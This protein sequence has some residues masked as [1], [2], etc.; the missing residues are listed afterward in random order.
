MT[1][2]QLHRFLLQKRPFEL[3]T[4]GGESSFSFDYVNGTLVIIS[5][6]NVSTSVP[7]DL[8]EKVLKRYESLPA[9]L[10]TITTQFGNNWRPGC[11]DPHLC[12]WVARII[13]FYTTG[14]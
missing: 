6:G 13:H 9:N 3:E 5:S 10:R 8:F 11:P 7:E 1:P 14:N 4:F 12:P 2:L